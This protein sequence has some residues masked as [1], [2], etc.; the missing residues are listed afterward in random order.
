MKLYEHAGRARA[1]AY[2]LNGECSTSRCTRSNDRQCNGNGAG[3]ACFVIVHH[4]N[5][6]LGHST[7]N[8]RGQKTRSLFSMLHMAYESNVQSSGT[9]QEDH[10]H[11]ARRLLGIPS[12]TIPIT[13]LRRAFATIN[14]S[15]S[16]FS[17]YQPAYQQLQPRVEV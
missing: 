1:V 7:D 10:P 2:V 11:L 12:I 8:R 4:F 3:A 16:S 14:R 9:I 6:R 17:R 5:H 13:C 15:H